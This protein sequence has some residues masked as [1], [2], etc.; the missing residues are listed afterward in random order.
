MDRNDGK[1]YTAS[2]H[3]LYEANDEISD[4]LPFFH[5]FSGNYPTTSAFNGIGKKTAWNALKKF[6][7]LESAVR[8]LMGDNSIE[9][10]EPSLDVSERFVISMYD[11]KVKHRSLGECRRVLFSIK[12]K[13][14]DKI[15]PTRD[16]LEQHIKRALL[17]ASIWTQCL[18]K[19]TATYKP[20]EWGW[21]VTGTGKYVPQWTTILILGDQCQEL[22]SC[23]CKGKCNRCMCS[24]EN[25]PCTKLCTCACNSFR[26][27][28]LN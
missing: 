15:P 1:K 7:G 8:D 13:P 12:R 11:P 16:A 4:I 25:L 23:N 20:E 27:K 24:K 19:N 28:T 2:V 21:M 17:Q 22:I 9:W 10:N 5:A 18:K 6:E 14:I 26:E 3:K